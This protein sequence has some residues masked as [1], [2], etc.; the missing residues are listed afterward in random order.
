MSTITG[1][2]Q[3][4]TNAPWVAPQTRQE[5]VQSVAR[6]TEAE[7][8]NAGNV[9][10]FS[11]SSAADSFSPA[12]ESPEFLTNVESFLSESMGIELNFVAHGSGAVVQVIDKNSGKVVREISA[13]KLTRF[14]GN[15]E[16]LRGILFDGQA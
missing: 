8:G 6:I 1:E 2:I 16:E 10:D 9:K 13:K 15:M 14:R 7:G 12:P 4:V 3:P 11:E 5:D